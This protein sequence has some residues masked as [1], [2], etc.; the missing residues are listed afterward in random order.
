[1]AQVADRLEVL[2]RVDRSLDYLFRAWEGVP[3]L[4]AEW[5]D[6]DE[7]SRFSFALDWPI[8]EDRLHQLGLWAA[9]GLLTPA[10]RARYDDLLALVAAHRPTLER[11]LADY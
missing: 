7:H 6:W 4:A 8:R 9:Q 11:L 10:Q 5:D 1:M 3:H 2:P